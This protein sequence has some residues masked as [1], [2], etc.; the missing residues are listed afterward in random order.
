VLVP[1]VLVSLSVLATTEALESW[2]FEASKQGWSDSG[3]WDRVSASDLVDT[4]GGIA[5][6]LNSGEAEAHGHVFYFGDKDT[7]YYGGSVSP[8][9]AAREGGLSPHAGLQ[10]QGDLTSPSVDVEGQQHVTLRFDH[11]RQ[12]EHYTKG[13]Y[14]RTWVEVRFDSGDWQT[15]WFLDSKTPSTAAWESVAIDLVVP[16]GSKRLTVRFRFDSVDGYANRYLGWLIDNVVIGGARAVISPEELPQGVV[17]VPYYVEIM[18]TEWG[19]DWVWFVEREELDEGEEV[20]LEA[21][22]RL[23]AR[24]E[25]SGHVLV[26]EGVPTEAVREIL[27]VSILDDRGAE[28]ASVDYDLVIREPGTEGLGAEYEFAT[29]EGWSSPDPLSGGVGWHHLTSEAGCAPRLA[30]AVLD[31]AAGLR[32]APECWYFG[33]PTTGDYQG[34]GRV[35]GVLVSGNVLDGADGRPSVGEVEGEAFTISFLHWRQVEYFKG[36]AYDITKLEISFDGGANWIPLWELN[37]KTA[38]KQGWEQVELSEFESGDPLTVPEGASGLWLRFTFD[39][40][41]GV[42][43]GFLGW[44]IDHVRV[45]FGGVEVPTPITILTQQLPK[46]YVDEEYEATLSA[47]GGSGD[48]VWT[49]EVGGDDLNDPASP[50][51]GLRYE[52]ATGR[53]Y[54]T[55]ESPDT[56]AL[57]VSV[58]DQAGQGAQAEFDLVIEELGSIA[59]WDFEADVSGW[60]KSGLWHVAVGGEDNLPNAVLPVGQHAFYYGKASTGN[61]DAGVT[62]GYLTSPVIDVSGVAAFKVSWRYFREVEEYPGMYDVTRVQLKLSDDPDEGEWVTIW[63]KSSKDPTLCVTPDGYTWVEVLADDN[64]YLTGGKHYLQIRFWFSSGDAMNNDYMGWLVDDVEVSAASAAEA[65]PLA[66]AA[67]APAAPAVRLEVYNLPNPVRDVHTTR[68]T[69]RG[70]EVDAIRVEIYDLSGRLVWSGEAPEGELEWHTDDLAGTWV[71][72]GVYLY[73]AYAR[74]AGEWVFLGAHKL[75]VLR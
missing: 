28:V 45:V 32:E 71:A 66:V 17:G 49:V 8:S 31:D 23:V 9:A 70:G 19:E 69:V 37:S 30:G 40:K 21:V 12:V 1:L 57:Q 74:M 15:V 73:L 34:G 38:S 20:G 64:K 59:Y 6:G 46:G 53:I 75:V 51:P 65:G 25:R 36:G 39:S 24:H 2:D 27:T 63:T 60:K 44:L 29:E 54:G 35:R 16:E 13:S 42:A 56:Y 3:L 14:D 52:P 22:N 61:Y 11:L 48:Y 47:T 26:I 4:E 18:S 33:N 67:V 41:D 58:T 7:G 72:N 5:A 62:S 55:P 43:N 10:V 68:F 50:I